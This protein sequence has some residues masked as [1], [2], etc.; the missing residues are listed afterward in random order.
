MTDR[1][2]AGEAGFG[3]SKSRHPG[4]GLGDLNDLTLTGR[5]VRLEPIDRRHVDGL[6]AAA[7]T[8][9]TIYQWSPV[10]RGAIAT[11]EYVA[12]GLG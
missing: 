2:S 11:S 4:C 9:P 6:A 8:D 7:S 1:T 3:A 12:S 10:P 5:H